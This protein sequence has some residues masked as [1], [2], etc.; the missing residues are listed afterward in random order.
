MTAKTQTIVVTHDTIAGTITWTV[1]G[2]EPVI[3]T[4][5]ALNPDFL[6]AAAVARLKDRGTDRAALPRDP[7]TGASATA[8]EKRAAI[9]EWV[10]YAMS[11]TAEW[12]MRGAAKPKFGILHR[13]LR[14]LY[15]SQDD[16]AIAA[17]LKA[18]SANERGTLMHAPSVADAIAAIRAEDAKAAPAPAPERAAGLLA[19]FAPTKAE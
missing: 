13:A 16:A 10:A 14:R 8:E 5:A 7:A 6:M 2:Q 19:R 9:A 15:P 18:M 12:D 17:T 4:L 11:G 3:L 1:P